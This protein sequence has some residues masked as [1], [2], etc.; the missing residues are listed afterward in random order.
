MKASTSNT[1]GNA[2]AD[3]EVRPKT[4]VLVHPKVVNINNTVA[5]EK[6]T[7]RVDP[8]PS[9]TSNSPASS[10]A[11]PTAGQQ[12]NKGSSRN[13]GKEKADNSPPKMKPP[14]GPRFVLCY[15]CG[16][17]FGEASVTIHEPQCLEKWKIENSKL[18]KGLRRPIPKKPEAMNITSGG[19]YDMDAMNEAAWKS[20]QAQLIPCENCGRTFAPDR[21]P[22]HQKAC[23]PKG[24][25]A[26]KSAESGPGMAINHLGINLSSCML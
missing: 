10:S 16:R 24:A 11:T 13:S 2:S 7:T 15:I 1:N 12:P 21:L 6:Q 5:L 4:A 9:R 25:A 23:R 3:E 19:K 18:P 22:V 17:K 14:P 8:S 20:A 26:S